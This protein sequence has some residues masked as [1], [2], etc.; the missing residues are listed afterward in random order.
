MHAAMN[1][2]AIDGVEL[3]DGVDDGLRLLRGGGVVEIDQGLA[4][5][6]LLEDRE[7]FAEFGDVEGGLDG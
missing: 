3:D 1:V 5:D 6:S 4:V 7:V 2:G